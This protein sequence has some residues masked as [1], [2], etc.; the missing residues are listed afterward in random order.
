VLLKNLDKDKMS[1]IGSVQNIR[2]DSVPNISTANSK[3]SKTHGLNHFFPDKMKTERQILAEMKANGKEKQLRESY[4]YLETYQKSGRLGDE[5]EKVITGFTEVSDY[6]FENQFLKDS[7]L[8]SYNK[9]KECMKNNN[10]EKALEFYIITLK[11]AL[12]SFNPLN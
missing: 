4:R 2:N 3:D 5:F 1:K 7:A 6:L 12:P 8:I 9:A 10:S 11:H